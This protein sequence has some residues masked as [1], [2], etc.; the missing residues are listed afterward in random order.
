MKKIF[1]VVVMLLVGAVTTLQA[2]A[3]TQSEDVMADIIELFVD[4]KGPKPLTDFM[5]AIFVQE[6]LVGTYFEK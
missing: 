5:I 6:D 4:Y 3:M 2:Q 1:Y